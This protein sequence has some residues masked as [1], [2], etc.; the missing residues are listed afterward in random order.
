[1][2]VLS[3]V[4]ICALNMSLSTNSIG[5]YQ[6][7]KMLTVPGTVLA[8]FLLYQ[9]ALPSPVAPS[10]HSLLLSSPGARTPWRSWALWLS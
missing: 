3:V 8:S 2:A 1:M 5:V 7:A 9:C 4:S 6:L 10:A